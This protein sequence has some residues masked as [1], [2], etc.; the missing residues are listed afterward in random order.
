MLRNFIYRGFVMN[1]VK[2]TLCV[3]LA[4]VLCFCAFADVLT[5]PAEA[6]PAI[7]VAAGAVVVWIFGLL[8]LH[9]ASMNAANDAAEAFYNSDTTI[10]TD[11]DTLVGAL[12]LNG[13]SVKF[14]ITLAL[15]PV[16][17][18]LMA[19]AKEFFSSDKAA[20]EIPTD[21]YTNADFPR[22]KIHSSDF[23][24][25]SRYEGAPYNMTCYRVHPLG[26]WAN[27][28]E[29]ISFDAFVSLGEA[30]SSGDYRTFN[31]YNANVN[32][33]DFSYNLRATVRFGSGIEYW[34]VTGDNYPYALDIV[35]EGAGDS[36]YCDFE[37]G[38]TLGYSWVGASIGSYD[39]LV[40]VFFI[41]HIDSSGI[42]H[43]QKLDT[44]FYPEKHPAINAERVAPVVNNIPYSNI[45]VDIS[46]LT[47]AIER[48]QQTMTETQETILD[49]TDV[50][51]ALTDTAEG[52]AEDEEMA[53]VPYV[54]S[55]EWL[56]QILRDLGLTLDEIKS[57]TEGAAENVDSSVGSVKLEESDFDAPTLPD[58][59][60][61]FPF[62]VPF[63]L[64]G[65]I[66]AL[67][68]EPKAPK[69]VIPLQFDKINFRYD[70]EID[71]APFERVA[72]VCR[73]TCIFSFLV[74]LALVTRKIIQA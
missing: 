51:N 66:S 46:A 73:W 50:Y 38:D 16:V 69:F 53:K 5:M 64:I 15:L 41:Q 6:A 62:C 71:F 17:N 35:P 30:D 34:C 12:A 48:L 56:K 65:I 45:G 21:Y 19:A 28:D 40:P 26:S 44:F 7:V 68:A 61:K 32:G 23:V 57:I 70:I 59:K 49:L 60:D 4:L 39:Y 1:S 11:V 72:E 20:V 55:L 52:S 13:T 8:G 18:R 33:I 3:F 74:F 25:V 24:T 9:F 22:I 36:S 42:P 31:I 27:C 63:D 10:K 2:K 14:K 29:F 54:P 58:L 37:K 47:A 43:Y 67:N